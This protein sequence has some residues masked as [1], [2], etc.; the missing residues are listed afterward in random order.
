MYYDEECVQYSLEAP[1]QYAQYNMI[2][3]AKEQYKP[4]FK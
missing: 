3:D 4:G 1:A 2:A